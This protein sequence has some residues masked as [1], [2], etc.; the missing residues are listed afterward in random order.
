[1]SKV[2]AAMPGNTPDSERVGKQQG[3]NGESKVAGNNGPSFSV[4]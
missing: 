2:W 1:M 3:D 4:C